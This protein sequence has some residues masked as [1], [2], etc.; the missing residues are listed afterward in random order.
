M[1]NKYYIVVAKLKDIEPA[2]VYYEWYEI[3][4]EAE[5]A[6]EEI[7]EKYPVYSSFIYSADKLNSEKEI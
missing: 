7:K 2:V 6:L 1:K 4:E 3:K 5:L